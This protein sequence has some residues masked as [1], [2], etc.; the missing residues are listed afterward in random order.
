M[1]LYTLK[2]AALCATLTLAVQSTRA[3]VKLPHLFASHMVLQRETTVPVWGW[4]DPDEPVTVAFAGQQHTT[5]ADAGGHWRVQLDALPAS[6]ESRDLVVTGRT[7]RLELKD[8]L[9]GDVWLAGGQSNMGF[10][11]NSAHNAAEVIPQAQDPQLRFFSVA[12]LTAAA[13]AEDCNGQWDLSTP[14]TAKNFSGVAYFFAREIRLDQHCPIAVLQA[15]WGGTDIETWISLDG[16]S[17][18]PPLTKVLDR[19]HKAV[20]QSQAVRLHPELAANYPADLKKWQAEVAPAFNAATKQYNADKAAGK[21]V[22]AK[23]QPSRPEPTNPD[24]MGVP[25]PSRRPATPTVNYNAMIAPLR[26]FALRGILWY[27]GEN[28]GSAGL[29]YRT[30]FPRLIQDWRAQWQSAGFASAAGLP[31]LFVQLPCNGADP[32]PVAKSGWPWLREAQLLTLAVSNTAMA[33]TIDIG[34]PNDVHPADKLDVGQR[35]ALA[36][37][38]LVYQENLVASGPLYQSFNPEAGGQLRLTF[39]ETGS[40]LII[41][42]SPWYAP[43]V[44]PF[45]KDRLTGFFVAGADRKWVAAE[46]RIDGHTVL[47]SSPQVAQ[48]VAVRYGW[49]NSPACNLYNKEGL[50]ASPFR[51]DNW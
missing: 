37:K 50:P 11:L 18:N 6:A 1:T 39:R 9:V 29:E 38:K 17:Q 5:T 40:G 33:I 30:L 49:A 41:G 22:G 19:W 46:A 35:L 3:E 36:A 15:P 32:V 4:A 25:S 45:S 10:P 31:F 44:K 43:G 8:V 14:A 47:V 48:P 2:T 16:L 28:N 26:P 34:N 23:P 20:E 13:P 24:P 42:Q 12:R 7:N 51:T 27:Q 21:P